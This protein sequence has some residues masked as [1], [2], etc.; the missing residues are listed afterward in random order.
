MT[1]KEVAEKLNCCEYGREISR[2]FEAELKAA[3]IVVVFGASDDLMEIRGAI[4]DETSAYGGV[5]IFVDSEGLLPDWDDIEKYGKPGYATC[6]NYFRREGY[7][8][9]IIAYWDIGDGI[10][11]SYETKIPHETFNVME[12][13]EVYCR[14]IVF[15]LADLPKAPP[16]P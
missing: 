13:G 2:V 14:G 10:S 7:G 9:G 6:R 16:A 8:V 4:F 3:G 11:W 1:P 12:D 15:A 5:E